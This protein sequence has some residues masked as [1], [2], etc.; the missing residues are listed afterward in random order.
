MKF[1]A[2]ALFAFCLITPAAHANQ[3]RD[4]KLV[5]QLADKKMNGEDVKKVI[6]VYNNVDGNPCAEQ[7]ISYL[8]HVSI[9]KSEMTEHPENGQPREWQKFNMYWIS[10]GD[11]D[12]GKDL[13]DSVCQ[14]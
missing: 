7:G 13:S 10:K 4:L 3:A 2:L 5:R 14:E 11:L 12:A 1:L 8:V 9:R 6:E